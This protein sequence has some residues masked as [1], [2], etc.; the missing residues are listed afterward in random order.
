MHY[1]YVGTEHILAGLVKE[2]TG[3]AAEVLSVNGV[4][5]SKLLSM[6]EELISIEMSS[7]R[8]S[9]RLNSSH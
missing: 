7:D 1:S 2:G 5:L 4:E 6:I 8:K 3:V 9:T